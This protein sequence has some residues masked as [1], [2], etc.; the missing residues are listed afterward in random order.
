MARDRTGTSAIVAGVAAEGEQGGHC[1]QL[2]A[3]G[4]DGVGGGET[5]EPALI[6]SSTIATRRSVTSPVSVRP[7]VQA[8]SVSRV[9]ATDWPQRGGAAGRAGG[10]NDVAPRQQ[11]GDCRHAHGRR[12]RGCANERV[13]IEPEVAVV[14]G[15]VREVAA[16]G[17]DESRRPLKKSRLTWGARTAAVVGFGGR[18]AA[19]DRRSMVRG[20]GG[21]VGV[22]GQAS[23]QA[24][25]RSGRG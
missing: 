17:R 3:G 7:S 22:A 5:A 18:S 9:S 14:A 16:V 4:G 24:S 19:L 2:A 11:I 13:E 12:R 20:P 8:K 1:D 15:C 21:A 6:A 25:V 10:S 23:A